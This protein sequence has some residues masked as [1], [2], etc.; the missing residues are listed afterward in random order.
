ML[1]SSYLGIFLG[2]DMTPAKINIKSL[3]GVS[4]TSEFSCTSLSHLWFDTDVS[5]TLLL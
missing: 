1:V 2:Q 3:F 5:H 4:W